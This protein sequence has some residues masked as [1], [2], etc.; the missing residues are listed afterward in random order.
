[1][2]TARHQV[3]RGGG[4]PR[5]KEGKDLVLKGLIWLTR[6]VNRILTF[7]YFFKLK[8]NNKVGSLHVQL[9]AQTYVTR[10]NKQDKNNNTSIGKG[11]R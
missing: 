1:V 6:W 9:G 11:M 5:K 7:Y 2:S 8:L 4:S 10:Y 3:P